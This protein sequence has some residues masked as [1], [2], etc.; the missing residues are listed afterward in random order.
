MTAVEETQQAEA[1]DFL[2]DKAKVGSDILHRIHNAMPKGG[3]MMYA[4]VNR[5]FTETSGLGLAEQTS[6][7]MNPKTVSKEEY[8]PGAIELWEEKSSRHG[9]IRI[10]CFS[11]NRIQ[12]SRDI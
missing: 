10:G 12:S 3:I 6:Q 8:I 11:L 7:L 5:W 9:I 2:V 1:E 4:E